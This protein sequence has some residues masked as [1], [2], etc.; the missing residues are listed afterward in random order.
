MRIL[1]KTLSL[2]LSF[3][4]AWIPVLLAK[5]VVS[6][7]R[8]PASA[9]DEA[10]ENLVRVIRVSKERFPDLTILDSN[11]AVVAIEQL[12]AAK[13]GAKFFIKMERETDFIF[14]VEPRVDLK[15]K[16][17]KILMTALNS[18]FTES[19]KGGTVVSFDPNKTASE[20]TYEMDATLKAFDAKLG[21]AKNKDLQ[22]RDVASEAT[23]NIGKVILSICAVAAWLFVWTQMISEIMPPSLFFFISLVCVGI[24]LYVSDSQI[25]FRQD[26]V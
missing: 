26:I 2:I 20:N 25:V 6:A 22:K 11:K 18:N 1:M 12:S 16:S 23:Q 24:Y 7:K 21:I 5:E 19:P 17:V 14:E 3:Q 8:A 15:N 9:K 10:K 4:L 13:L